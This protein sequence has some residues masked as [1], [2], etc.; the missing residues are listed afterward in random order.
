MTTLVKT[1]YLN[2]VD[3]GPDK[4]KLAGKIEFINQHGEIT[5]RIN[6]EQAEKI[7]AVL[8]ENLVATAKQ[9]ATLMTAEVLAQAAG[10]ELIEG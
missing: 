9:T 7:V 5:V 3:Y 1:L 4:G 6:N 10:V 8:A 2:M